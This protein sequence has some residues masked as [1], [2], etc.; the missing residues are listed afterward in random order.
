MGVFR[1]EAAYMGHRT[2]RQHPFLHPLQLLA[3]AR[4][5]AEKEA[6][7]STS[8]PE[9]LSVSGGCFQE[10]ERLLFTTFDPV[11]NPFALP[12]QHLGESPETAEI[13]AQAGA[14]KFQ[15]TSLS[16]RVFPEG[17]RLLCAGPHPVN[18]PSAL[19]CRTMTQGRYPAI[20]AQNA[21]LLSR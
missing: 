12:L 9:G 17:E 6:L 21:A 8:K 19:D 16:R 7:T 3:E 2:L 4:K 13:Q 20:L 15:G 14:A 1:R 10:G 5:T 11:N 18:N